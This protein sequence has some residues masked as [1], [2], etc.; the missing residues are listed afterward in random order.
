MSLREDLKILRQ[1]AFLPD[2]DRSEE[3]NQKAQQLLRSL[4]G[5]DKYNQLS[6]PQRSA[7]I[8]RLSVQ[9]SQGRDAAS[10]GGRE[11]LRVLDML[12]N[13]TEMG[14][15]NDGIYHTEYIRNKP[16]NIQGNN[17]AGAID[18]GDTKTGDFSTRVNERSPARR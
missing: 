9:P 13:R 17:T 3:Q 15:Y 8:Q 5:T 2:K 10:R 12:R 7:A 4:L 18:F 14:S 1:I 16:L 6:S 11:A